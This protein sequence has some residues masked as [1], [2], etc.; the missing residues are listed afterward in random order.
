MITGLQRTGTTLLQNLLSSDPAAR[1][2]HSFENFRPT[3]RRGALAP[4]GDHRLLGQQA[5]W[6]L[7]KTAVPDFPRIHWVEAHEPDECGML[8]ANTF[9]T[10][11]L[12]ATVPTPEYM[13]WFLE[14]NLVP[15]YEH[16]RDTLKILQLQRPGRRWVLKCPYHLWG[17]E[18]ML[19][20][21]PNAVFVQTHRRMDRVIPSTCSMFATLRKLDSHHVDPL[22]VGA[23]VPERWAVALER[24]LAARDAVGSERF[25]DV[26]Y[27]D[28]VGDPFGTVQRIYEHAGLPWH[29]GL[30][31]PMGRWLEGNPADKRGQ[32]DYSMEQFGLS[33]GY[34]RELF[35]EYEDRFGVNT[36][37]PP[38]PAPSLA[39]VGT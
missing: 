6:W 35:G 39:D 10:A 31:E 29:E 36:V 27:E 30:R 4:T 5:R 2:L 7:V 22:E 37:E 8:L 14:Q 28:L 17:L 18:A 32:H 9:C 13:D 24:A 20:V 23:E 12:D 3:T 33:Q 1:T 16:Y 34:L 11:M 15:A 26:R 21:F 25:I 38:R 19:E